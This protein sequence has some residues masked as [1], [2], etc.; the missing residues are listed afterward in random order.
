MDW[1]PGTTNSITQCKGASLYSDGTLPGVYP[2]ES[3]ISMKVAE[4]IQE[5]C[6]SVGIPENIK[7]DR[8]S[9]ICE[10]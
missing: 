7:S 9:D 10:Y 5:L 3:N 1:I 2:K 8:A 4:K 6:K